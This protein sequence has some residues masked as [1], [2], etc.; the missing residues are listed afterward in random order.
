VYNH[1]VRDRLIWTQTRTI[2]KF[3]DSFG[4]D[5][6]A[7]YIEYGRLL[8]LRLV[9]SSLGIFVGRV[10]TGMAAVARGQIL[11]VGLNYINEQD[12]KVECYRTADTSML[13]SSTQ[14]E[15]DKA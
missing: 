15:S 5:F 9:G 12:V 3:P 11:K 8:S 1:G 7:E 10:V 14:E 13:R 4:F 6:T 2:K